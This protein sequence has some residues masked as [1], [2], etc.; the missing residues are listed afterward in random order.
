MARILWVDKEVCIS[1]GACIDECPSVFRFDENDKSEVY[2]QNGATES[3]IE[4]A[5][6][7]C[8]VHCIHWK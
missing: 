7:V 5:I 1:C 8:P 6:D 4:A 3:E 2:N